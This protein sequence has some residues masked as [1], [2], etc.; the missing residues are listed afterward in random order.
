MQTAINERQCEKLINKLQYAIDNNM[1]GN[2]FISNIDNPISKIHPLPYH[3]NNPKFFGFIAKQNIDIDF[4]K[5]K[6]YVEYVAICRDD[7]KI[8]YTLS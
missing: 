1:T 5:N 4:P 7:T 8:K 2:Q 6:T 3:F